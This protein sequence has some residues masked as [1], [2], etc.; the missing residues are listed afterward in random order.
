MQSRCIPD[1][2][3]LPIFEQVWK[4]NLQLIK[5]YK[6]KKLELKQMENVNGGKFSERRCAR[7][8]RRFMRSRSERLLIKYV[9]NC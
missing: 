3:L 2:E 6:M 5:F 1:L 8:S 9:V 4:I 7:I